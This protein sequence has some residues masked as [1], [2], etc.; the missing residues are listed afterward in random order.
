LRRL[1]RAISLAKYCH[2]DTTRTHTHTHTYVHT[3]T[4]TLP[5]SS[6]F[7]GQPRNLKIKGGLGLKSGVGV[8]ID[9]Y[10]HNKDVPGPSLCRYLAAFCR[11]WLTYSFVRILFFL[12]AYFRCLFSCVV[13]C[14]YSRCPI[15]FCVPC[16]GSWCSG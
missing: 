5:A 3:R 6:L 13:Q 11:A 2:R 1:S 9:N 4:H 16:C 8:G 7:R 12:R 10:Y 14:T 15:Q